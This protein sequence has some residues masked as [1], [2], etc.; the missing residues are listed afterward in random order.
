MP[1]L[2]ELEGCLLNTVKLTTEEIETEGELAG[3]YVFRGEDGKKHLW[4]PNPWGYEH[5]PVQTVAE[6][7]HVRFLCPACF[8]KNGGANGTHS[9]FITFE[10]RGVPLE[11]GSRDHAGNP[12]RWNASGNGIDD[13]VLTP[14]IALDV[15]DAPE[16]GCHWHGFVGSNG[17]PPGSAY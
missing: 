10:G 9:V 12:S 8:V 16:R 1:T 3:K 7:H 6:A 4:S 2:R 13:L 17:V 11:I 15:G 5:H 14:S